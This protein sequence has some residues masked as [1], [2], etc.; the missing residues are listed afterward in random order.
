MKRFGF[1]II[2]ITCITLISGCSSSTNN[3]E[4]IAK[5][6]EEIQVLKQEI[7]NLKKAGDI[8]GISD[9]VKEIRISENEKQADVLFE[10]TDKAY[11]F[12][13]VIIDSKLNVNTIIPSVDDLSE[14]KTAK[15]VLRFRFKQED[16]RMIIFY[17]I[18]KK[19]GQV[20]IDMQ[21][22]VSDI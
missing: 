9:F 20:L 7:V 6:H 1:I 4:E 15:Y 10:E 17:A 18:D 22:Y 14:G 11:F 3:K 13:I 8:S 16:I 21:E 5:L 12:Q 2:L 19:S